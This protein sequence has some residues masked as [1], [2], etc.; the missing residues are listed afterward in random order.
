[1]I[2]IYLGKKLDSN[3]EH[4]L[5]SKSDKGF[6]IEIKYNNK[7]KYPDQIVNQYT[8]I[9]NLY[10]LYNNIESENRIAF[11]SDILQTGFNR[12]IEHIDT[13]TITE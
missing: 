1:M 9:H 6:T 4:Y 11:E 10:N 7:S 13:I 2:L 5:T 12:L 8:D 3:K